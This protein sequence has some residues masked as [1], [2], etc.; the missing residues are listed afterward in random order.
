MNGAESCLTCAWRAFCQKRFSL[1]RSKHIRCPDFTTDVTLA[2]DKS[3]VELCDKAK[4]CSQSAK[5]LA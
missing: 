2:S 3:N 1:V 5:A 4:N